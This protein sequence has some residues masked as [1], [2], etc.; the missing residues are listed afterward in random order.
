[1]TARIAS[2]LVLILLLTGVA[3][4]QQRLTSELAGRIE[5]GVNKLTEEEVL[6]LVPGP[7]TVTF[8]EDLLGNDCLL[9]WKEVREIRV[10][11]LAE[12]ASSTS[13]TFT[14]VIESKTLT[15]ANLK[16]I[17][18]GMKQQEV[19]KLLDGSGALRI[20]AG[21]NFEG[22]DIQICEWEDGRVLQAFIKGGKVSGYRF[23]SSVR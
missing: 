17:A 19:L 20:S 10:E 11:F 21:K 3:Q 9:T 18:N 22:K 5:K 14:D 23:V 4:G 7:V 15:L 13:G 1:M 12:K 6:K 16:K 8:G 2:S